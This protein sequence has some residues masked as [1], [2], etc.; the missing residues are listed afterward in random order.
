MSDRATSVIG[1]SKNMTYD[2]ANNCIFN[3]K[4]SYKRANV[5]VVLYRKSEDYNQNCYSLTWFP[6]YYWNNNI[7]GNDWSTSVQSTPNKSSAKICNKNA[8]FCNSIANFVINL[9]HWLTQF[10]TKIYHFLLYVIV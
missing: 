10:P 9:F 5:K 7:Y 1:K 6:G 2:V 8:K 4:V 3:K